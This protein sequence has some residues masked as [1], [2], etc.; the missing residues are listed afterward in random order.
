[1]GTGTQSLLRKTLRKLPPFKDWEFTVVV[2]LTNEYLDLRLRGGWGSSK[3]QDNQGQKI[4]RPWCRGKETSTLGQKKARFHS[5][6]RKASLGMSSEAETQ[7]CFQSLPEN[8]NEQQ[9]KCNSIT[10]NFLT[11]TQCCSFIYFTL[12]IFMASLVNCYDLYFTS[13]TSGAQG[14]RRLWWD[15][16]WV[17]PGSP[18]ERCHHISVNSCLRLHCAQLLHKVPS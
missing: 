9:A 15:P 7:T 10:T 6:A 4:R 1:M 14:T 3:C 17:S 8:L 13:D 11:A 5:H 2:I 16:S 12:I 18:S